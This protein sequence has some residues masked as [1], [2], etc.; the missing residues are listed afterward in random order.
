M[1]DRRPPSPHGDRRPRWLEELDGQTGYSPAD[2]SNP[3]NPPPLF[4]DCRPSAPGLRSLPPPSNSY[5]FTLSIPYPPLSRLRRGRNAAA[6][7]AVPAAKA[8]SIKAPERTRRCLCRSIPLT[9]SFTSAARVSLLYT[10]RTPPL[11]K[12]KRARHAHGKTVDAARP[13][14]WRYKIVRREKGQTYAAVC[15]SVCLSSVYCKEALLVKPPFR[16]IFLQRELYSPPAFDIKIHIKLY[17]KRL[18]KATPI[19]KGLQF[20]SKIC[21]VRPFGNSRPAVL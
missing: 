13:L 7:R 12:R 6:P 8:A 10:L 21:K 1:P 18:Q 4:G 11:P 20:I 3:C 17:R 19:P 15:L 16:K 14:I 2:L 9:R 5:R